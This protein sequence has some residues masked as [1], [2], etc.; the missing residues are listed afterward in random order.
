MKN[1]V[2]IISFVAKS[3]IRNVLTVLNYLLQD[4]SLSFSACYEFLDSSLFAYLVDITFCILFV[5]IYCG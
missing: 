2:F 5:H 4:W 3:F 1:I